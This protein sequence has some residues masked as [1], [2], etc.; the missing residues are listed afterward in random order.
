[1]ISSDEPNLLLTHR[2]RDRISV[3]IIEEDRDA[4]SNLHHI[5]QML[6][7]KECYDARDLEGAIP[8]IME[9][10][11]THL[12]FNGEMEDSPP[13]FL[14]K[15]VLSLNSSLACI[16]ALRSPGID[17]VFELLGTGASGFLVKPFTSESVDSALAH[18]SRADHIPDAIRRATDRNEA[19][20]S[21][22]LHSFS[23][24]AKT[25]SQAKKYETAGYEIPNRMRQFRK[26]ADMAC[27]F[28]RGGKNVLQEEL[29][30]QLEKKDTEPTTHLGKIRR[31]VRPHSRTPFFKDQAIN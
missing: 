13:D 31:Q 8:L 15:K 11:P 25:L 12:I 9:H 1:M 14:L 22:L 26:A 18:A 21:L 5:I 19:L 27:M 30:R 10:G 28:A 3:V 7:V 16:P 29:L 24:A 2:Q 4:R 20:A 6:G 23:E 17:L